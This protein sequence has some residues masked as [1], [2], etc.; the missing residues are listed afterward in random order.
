MRPLLLFFI[1]LVSVCAFAATPERALMVREASLYLSPDATSQK[2][3][4][5]G[6]GREVAIIEGSGEWLHVL[7]NVETGATSIRQEEYSAPR[8]VT[9]WLR[10]KGVIRTST[11]KGDEILYGEAV[12]SEAQASRRGGRKG[13]AQD[14]LRLYERIAEYFPKS[15]FAGE[16]AFR[17]ADIRW[18]LEREEARLRPSSRLNDRTMRPELSEEQLKNVVKKFPHTKWADLAAYDLLDNKM[19]GDW[20]GASKCPDKEADLYEKYAAEHPE[21]P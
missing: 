16:A 20:Q 2:I 3:G 9:G 21:S 18:Q 14:A 19:C 4:T 15:P 6:R 5:V 17:A 8:D 7:A 10:G 13:A 11:P 1:A 12:D